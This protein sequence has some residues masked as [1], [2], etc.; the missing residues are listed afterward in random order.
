MEKS[1]NEKG[2]GGFRQKAG[3]I[4]CYRFAALCRDA[5]T[6]KMIEN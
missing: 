5:A 4:I 2:R 3:F 1:A 6:T